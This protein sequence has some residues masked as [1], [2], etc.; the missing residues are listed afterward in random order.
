MHRC[1][2]SKRCTVM[3]T[4]ELN[5]TF[6]VAQVCAQLNVHSNVY[7]RNRREPKLCAVDMHNYVLI[8][9]GYMLIS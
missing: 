9:M 4:V 6:S 3:Y 1:A 2:H 5:E 8:T 7:S